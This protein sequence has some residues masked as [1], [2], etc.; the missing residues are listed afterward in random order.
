MSSEIVDVFQDDQPILVNG[1]LIEAAKENIQPL[2]SGRRATALSAVLSTPHAQRESKLAAA[3]NRLRINVEIALED[4]DDNPL[5][6]Y[7][8]LVYWTLE[9]YPQGHRA[10]SGLLELVEEATRVLKDHRGGIW[11]DDLRYLK[12]CV[13]RRSYTNEIGTGFALLYEEFATVLGRNGRRVD[14]D[15][16]YLLGINR[17]ASPVDHLQAKYRE[18]QKRMMLAAPLDSAS[19][20]PEQTPPAASTTTATRRKVLGETSSTSGSVRSG[21]STSTRAAAAAATSSRPLEDVFGST[22]S[23]PS[24]RP[25][26]NARM[27]VFVD[28]SGASAAEEALANGDTMTTPWNELGSRKER[29]KENVPK[30]S[31]LSG[32]TLRQQHHV[33]TCSL[34]DRSFQGPGVG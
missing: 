12:L 24:S 34:S 7:C 2:A 22:S 20:T 15:E 8:R 30:V 33:R 21:H 6:A 32:T 5:E 26:P 27:Q 1:D 3:R 17:Q 29:I 9:N 4:D 23:G 11:R 25:K 14:A 13:F 28:P 10:E 16:T 31:K 19:L 18:F